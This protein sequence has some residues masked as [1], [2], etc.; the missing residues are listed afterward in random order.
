MAT[1]E[2]P[3]LFLRKGADD[4]LVKLPNDVAGEIVG[5]HAQQA[6][7][8]PLKAVLLA[9]GAHASRTHDLQSFGL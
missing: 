4:A 9:K 6:A 3:D 5:F 7:E 1:P 8:K 2:G